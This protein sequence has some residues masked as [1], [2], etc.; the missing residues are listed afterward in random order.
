MTKKVKVSEEV[1]ATPTTV[2]KEEIKIPL[3]AVD[4]I[5]Q[6]IYKTAGS[7]I[8]KVSNKAL[9][10]VEDVEELKNKAQLKRD[11]KNNA[12]IR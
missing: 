7:M 9:R 5:N 4:K 8:Q 6:Y 2:E 10:S 1:I 12:R 3:T 11:R